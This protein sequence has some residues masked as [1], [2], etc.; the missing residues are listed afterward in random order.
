MKPPMRVNTFRGIGIF[1]I[2][3]ALCMIITAIVA[4][5]IGSGDMS[6][7]K[8]RILTLIQD[9]LMFVVPAI[10]TAIMVTRYPATFLGID[11]KASLNT[12]IMA[13]VTLVMAMP[14]LNRIIAWNEALTLPESMGSLELAMR[15]YEENAA[16]M[17]KMML[18]PSTVGNLIVSLLIVGVLA[19]FSEELFFRGTLQRLLTSSRATAHIAIWVTA[20][21]F[22]AMHVQFFGFFPRL[23]LGAFFGYLFYWSGCLW[24]PILIH[25]LNNCAVVFVEWGIERGMWT[26]S[27]DSFG[28]GEGSALYVVVSVVLTCLSL[29]LTRKSAIQYKSE[30][31]KSE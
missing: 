10:V 18:G 14:A 27:V 25:S 22:S 24:L 29:Y 23:L 3:T 12:I 30:Q 7:L 13:V 20:F 31:S 5:V 11:C 15:Q 6:T 17:V 8:L 1:V 28:S 26:K 21:I 4:G 2:V 19:G 9:I 16:A